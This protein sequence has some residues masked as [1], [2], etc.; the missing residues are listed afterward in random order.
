M[1][2]IIEP[3]SEH[4]VSGGYLFNREL[5]LASAGAI[6]RSH[7]LETEMAKAEGIVLLDSLWLLHPDLRRWASRPHCA[8]ILHGLPQEKAELWQEN[9]GLFP[10]A[11][12]PSRAMA[13]RV[14]ALKPSMEILI[15]EPGLHPYFFTSVL[16]PDYRGPLRFL[17]VGNILPAKGYTEA[18]RF[19]Q[20]L[21]KDLP[22]WTWTI[23]GNERVDA[24]YSRRLRL[25]IEAFGLKDRT[26]FLGLVDPKAGCYASS[27]IFFF[28]SRV[29]SFGMVLQE[30]AALGLPIVT[31]NVGIASEIL[32]GDPSAVL[33]PPGEEEKGRDAVRRLAHE[34]HAKARPYRQPRA[35]PLLHRSWETAV[36]ELRSLLQC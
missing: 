19:L 2:C 27:D 18:C 30:A 8:W 17:T 3:R 13:E 32:R 35:H 36:S 25:Q 29:E 15:C 7:E 21:D 14:K 12:V 20:D 6:R 1:I 22:P 24:D 4:A 26:R 11:V 34:L 33:L 10:K 5:E 9:L 23:A 31:T 16:R 28:F